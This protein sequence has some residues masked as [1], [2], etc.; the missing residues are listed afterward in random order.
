MLAAA[1]QRFLDG[2]K[3]IRYAEGRGAQDVAYYLALPYRDVTGKLQDQ[4]TI[5]GKS[6]RY[7]ERRILPG[8][9]TGFGRPLRIA[10]LGAGNCWMSYRLSLRGHEVTTVDLLTDPLHGLGAGSHYVPYAA[11]GRMFDNLPFAD[12]SV[13]L[14][15][16]N[17]SIHYS[18][19]YRRTLAEARRCLD[20]D[21]CVLIV[22]S[23]VY[24]K[25]EHGEQ[26]KEER[27]QQFH[28]TYGFRSD[29]LA[30]ESFDEEMLRDLG[31]DL[32][33]SWK[34]YKP[35]HGWQWALRPWK[36]LWQG[37]GPPSRFWILPGGFAG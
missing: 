26:T 25:R 13:D 27:H 10:D 29:A 16:Y 9:E 31:R 2:Y 37:K 3:K 17:A 7:V 18:T 5:R 34:V 32:G 8:I 24:R 1:R 22:D 21:G 36:A 12:A 23:P 15:V 11:F 35:W 30:S 14:V 6:Y 33:I 4:W 28:R 19:D 20:R